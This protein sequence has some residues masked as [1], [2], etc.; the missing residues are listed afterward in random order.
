MPDSQQAAPPYTE[1][2]L[3]AQARI[4][5]GRSRSDSWLPIMS[6]LRSVINNPYALEAH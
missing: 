6:V 2:P 1:A 3:P 5:F 4:H